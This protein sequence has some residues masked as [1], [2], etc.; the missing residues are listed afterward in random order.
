MFMFRSKRHTLSKRLVEEY[1]KR[2][3]EQTNDERLEVGTLLRRL[4]EKQLQMLLSAVTSRGQDST[5]CVLLPREDEPHVLC[6]RAWRWPDLRQASELRRMPMCR[7]AADSVY[8][9]CN[10]YHWSRLCLP[11]LYYKG[12]LAFYAIFRAL[13]SKL[14]LDSLTVCPTD[15]YFDETSFKHGRTRCF[16]S[17]LPVF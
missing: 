7:S 10:P 3:K 4:Q 2:A 11:A 5:N 16:L 1:R 12:P 14:G 17:S 15:E 9:C 8:I 6:C 13:Q